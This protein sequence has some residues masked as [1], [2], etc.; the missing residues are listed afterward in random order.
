VRPTWAQPARRARRRTYVA[1]GSEAPGG[2]GYTGGRRPWRSLWTWRRNR[3]VIAEFFDVDA[4]KWWH[5]RIELELDTARTASFSASVRG[6][7][8][9]EVRW[10]K[11]NENNETTIA[12]AIPEGS[13]EGS[14]EDRP[15]Q[16]QSQGTVPTNVGTDT[17]RKRGIAPYEV[18]GRLAAH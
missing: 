14:P 3:P 9:N 10:K 7:F 15:S 18:A 13:R 1:Q 17:R 12:G 2:G 8:G 4:G 5:R 11:S 16:S 6:K